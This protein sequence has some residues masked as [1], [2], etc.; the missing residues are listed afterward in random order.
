METESS[1]STQ[2]SA[3]R[4]IQYY[5]VTQL[6]TVLVSNLFFSFPM[7]K[8]GL[9]GAYDGRLEK[10]LRETPSSNQVSNF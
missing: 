8:G 7:L 6:D 2:V 3:P 4:E 5:T 10:T 9:F 1:I